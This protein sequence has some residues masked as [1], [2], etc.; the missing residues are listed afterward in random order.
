MAKRLL[1]GNLWGNFMA[2]G[3]VDSVEM[4]GSKYYLRWRVPA[5]FA[6]VETKKEINRSLRT[7]DPE[8]AR[9]LAGLA[10][11]ALRSELEARKL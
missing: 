5:E 10:K 8:K 3:C 4:R 1:C 6:E 2:V 7:R 9:T 11:E